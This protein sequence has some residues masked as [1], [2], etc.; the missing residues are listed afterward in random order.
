MGHTHKLIHLIAVQKRRN[1][2]TPLCEISR[3][4]QVFP[5]LEDEV[6]IFKLCYAVQEPADLR[7][8]VP[9]AVL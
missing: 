5:S 4:G 8:V 2:V 7:E 1:L 6:V 3:L 9:A